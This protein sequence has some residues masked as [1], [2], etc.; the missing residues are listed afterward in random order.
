VTVR[1]ASDQTRAPMDAAEW[2]LATLLFISLLGLMGL[3]VNAVLSFEESHQEL[4][5]AS[6]LA[7]LAAPVGVLL[8]LAATRE[9][10]RGEKRA[11]IAGLM[12]RKGTALLAAYLK[13]V[14]R[15]RATEQL[16][17]ETRGRRTSG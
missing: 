13:G 9:L 15:R 17:A 16:M 14:D 2:L 8:H 4:L 7:L 6:G 3:V 12:G 5:I 11:W 1:K 10:T